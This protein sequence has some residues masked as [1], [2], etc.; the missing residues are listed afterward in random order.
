MINIIEK[1]ALSIFVFLLAILLVFPKTSFTQEEKGDT[2]KLYEEIAGYY[3]F[4]TPDGPEF[5][6]FWVED[7][8]LKA[9]EDNDDEVVVL[10]PVEGKELY[11]ELT[12]PNGQL[13]EL[14][15]SRDEK[16]KITK[17]LVSVLGMEIEVV[18]I[19]K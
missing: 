4:E 3:E 19:K 10:E 13:Y 18:K 5:I 9:Q 15:F 17:C 12:D 8:V 1:S 16:G 14:Q 7:G 2:K 11:F 6:T